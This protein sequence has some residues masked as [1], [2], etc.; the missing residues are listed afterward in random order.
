MSRGRVVAT[1]GMMCVIITDNGFFVGH[2]FWFSPE[3]KT[4][5]ER[6]PAAKGTKKAKK[7]LIEFSC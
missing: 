7:V 2:Y 3:E 5:K 6:L 1:D 4:D